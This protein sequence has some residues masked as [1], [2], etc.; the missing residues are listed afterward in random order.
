VY[1]R[2]NKRV[3]GGLEIQKEKEKETSTVN[4]RIGIEKIIK[5]LS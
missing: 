2:K 1:K 4:L 5:T 3:F